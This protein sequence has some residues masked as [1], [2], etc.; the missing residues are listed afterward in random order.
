MTSTHCYH[1]DDDAD[2]IDESWMLAM[3]KDT[4]I[5][6]NI[7]EVFNMDKATSV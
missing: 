7:S 6:V 5:V 2:D 3:T 1:D 4:M